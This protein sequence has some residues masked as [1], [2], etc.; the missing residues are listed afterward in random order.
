MHR[1]NSDQTTVI[2]T[3]NPTHNSTT[4]LA[5]RGVEYGVNKPL[6][7]RPDAQTH[8]LVRDGARKCKH[9]RP[10]ESNRSD[11]T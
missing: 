9:Q 3:F 1:R 7:R 11:A 5:T 6:G 4:G 8:R 10:L 2:E